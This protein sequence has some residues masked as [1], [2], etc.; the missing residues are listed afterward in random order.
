MK[1][2]II[3]LIAMIIIFILL[4]SIPKII[5]DD[6][7]IEYKSLLYK[8]IKVHSIKGD[9]FANGIIIEL[10]GHIIINNVK[11]STSEKEMLLEEVKSEEGLIFTIERGDKNCV[12]VKLSVYDNGIYELSTSYGVCK[13]FKTCSAMLKY[14]DVEKG[15]YDYEVLKILQNSYQSDRERFVPKYEI[16]IGRDGKRYITADN[17]RYLNEF[18]SSINVNLNKCAV[19]SYY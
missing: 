11:I 2:K 7:V 16:Y 3:I 17:N 5:N 1:K 4:L 8:V 18:L 9:S 10:F 13:P 15:T 19:K 12:P 6:G 14:I